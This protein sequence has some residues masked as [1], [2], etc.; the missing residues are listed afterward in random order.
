MMTMRDFPTTALEWTLGNS[1]GA[2]LMILLVLGILALMRGQVALPIRLTIW[3]L[4]GARLLLPMAIPS[5]LS[6]LNLWPSA[7]TMTEAIPAEVASP[8]EADPFAQVAATTATASTGQE[9][10]SIGSALDWRSLSWSILAW[11]WLLVTIGLL[12]HGGL[13]HRRMARWLSRRPRVQD[14]AILRT[15]HQCSRASGVPLGFDVVS[16]PAGQAVAVFGFLRP[17]HLLIPE[18][19]AA[20]CTEV[21]IRGIFH[22]E[23]GHCRRQDLLWNWLAYFIR[24]LHWFNPL[25]WVVMSRFRA[26]QELSCD[27]AAL[28]H[29]EPAQRRDYGQALLKLASSASPSSCFKPALIPFFPYPSEI[30][31]RLTMIAKPQAMRVWIQLAACLAILAVCTFS[32]TTATAADDPGSSKP[33]AEA[34]AGPKDSP[35]AKAGAKD[36]P[37]AKSGPK[38]SPES[39]AKKTGPR[40]GDVKKTGPR[41][42]DVKKT[43]PKDTGV[44]G[45]EAKANPN[46]PTKPTSAVDRKDPKYKTREG[47]I[48]L[49]YDADGSGGVSAEEAA[50]MTEKE[51]SRREMRDLEDLIED[52]DKDGNDK[53]LNFEEFQRW[54][55]I[56]AGREG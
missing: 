15:L 39:G 40:D 47:K 54:R 41:D 46:A 7:A 10:A 14:P 25:V 9:I 27:R 43:G 34:K 5:Q 30:Q 23:L 8:A 44:P 24:T 37:E 31:Q 38:D 20:R 4:I 36:S 49:R 1:L 28:R 48:F 26:D 45:P 11:V 22:H 42:G 51:E 53:E 13:A 50:N 21:E 17:S 55:N 56:R 6:P 3:A 12:A 32:F 33:S 18:D 35:E 16:V 2:S 19:L 29:L 52:L